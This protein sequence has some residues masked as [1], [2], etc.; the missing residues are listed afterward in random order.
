MQLVDKA[1]SQPMMEVATARSTRSVRR[2]AVPFRKLEIGGLFEGPSGCETS[3]LESLTPLLQNRLLRPAEIGSLRTMEIRGI[4]TSPR[5]VTIA[6]R[7]SSFPGNDT[8]A[9]G[10]KMSPSSGLMRI[11]HRRGFTLVELLVVI[12]IIG[13]LVGLLLP[14]V[15]AAR[16][17]ARRSQCMNNLRQIG[18]GLTN[19]E[20]SFKRFPSGWVDNFRSNQTTQPGWA[21]GHSMLPFIEQGPLYQQ[22]DHRFNVDSMTSRP[23]L[24]SVVPTFLCP[25]DPGDSTFEIGQDTGEE[26]EEEHVGHNVDEGPKLFRIAKAN[27]VGVFGTLEV[28]EYPYNGDGV[29]F[30][31]S[32]IRARDIVDGLSNTMIV[33][34][35][36]SRLGGSVWHGVI[37]EAAEPLPR[38][39]GSTDHTPNSPAGHFD[40]FSSR[41]EA[42]AHFSFADCSTRI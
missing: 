36:S 3:P 29:F 37:P 17:A 20:S 6:S 19:Y 32:T 30:G 10:Q 21:W 31:N 35:R 23:F 5:M 18:L 2:L 22:I 24:T 8:I 40:D 38:F 1:V 27:Y 42:G 25:S 16:E 41:H 28:A 4:F 33:G 9:S 11:H 12:A 39:L 14:A 13:I 7:S 34:E 15:Q 26:E